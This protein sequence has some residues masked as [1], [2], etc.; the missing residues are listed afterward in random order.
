MPPTAEALGALFDDLS[1]LSLIG[2]G[3]MGAVYRA[4]QT[5]LDRI[6]ALK[7]LPPQRARDPIFVERFLR[8][9][10][11]L[12]SLSH[13]HVVGVFD[14][15]QA[16]DYL[17]I[18][19][20]YVD[21]ASL[22]T[23]LAS[24][25]LDAAETLRLV[26]QI[27]AA[28]QYAHDAGIVHRDIK[29][30][31]VLV[32]QQGQI[33]IADFGLAKLTSDGAAAD[34]SLTGD[35]ARLGT[36]RYMAPEQFAGTAGVDRRADIYSLGV[37][38]YELLTG[39][40][41]TPDFKRPSKRVGVDARVDRVIQR[42]LKNSP[43]ERYQQAAEMQRDVEQISAT[44]S[45]RK[46]LAGTFI[47]SVLV[48]LV[49]LLSWNEFSRRGGKQ[50]EGEPKANP[51]VS[52]ADAGTQPI[53]PAAQEISSV[54]LLTSP[55]WEWTKPECLE[56]AGG[57]RRDASGPAISGDELLL[58]FTSNTVLADGTSTCEQLWQARRATRE[59]PF[60]EPERLPEEVN[61][62]VLNF[63]PCLSAD[64]LTLIFCSP[65]D[66]KNGMMDLW[67]CTRGSVR[68]PWSRPENLG[69]GVNSSNSEWDPA[70]SADGLTLY[71]AVLEM[72]PD[73]ESDLYVAHRKSKGEPF[74]NA[75]P[76]GSGIND[77]RA[78]EGGPCISRD[79]L[80]LLFY[81][82]VRGERPTIF[83]ATRSSP[84]DPFERAEP[85]MLPPYEG[86]AELHPALSGDGRTLYFVSGSILQPQTTT[87]WR[88][89]RVPKSK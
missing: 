2:A 54:R 35:H 8:E 15:G 58:V 85:L 40:L 82:R 87:I 52:T 51:A 33:K 65:R 13:P 12:A 31:N 14:A 68:E 26:P 1:V 83:M 3:G 5:R 21:G 11:A 19:M 9:A 55:D 76:L 56:L 29:P 6:V 71:Y 38:F 63:Q 89:H 49:A 53:A 78:T 79:G 57:P 44:A 34:V 42:S 27:C 66:Q 30:E 32:D 62:N 60:G 45:W 72:G 81:R 25:R 37:M 41:P 28:L 74:M 4:K 39:D 18:V 23:L 46:T 20:E 48:G 73:K 22:R 10:R 69:P 88:T 61:G 43:P 77:P 80:S 36:A 84:S 17:Y 24:G 7:I 47:V 75:T 16:G 59:E 64:G 70:L 67:S 50:A 86:R